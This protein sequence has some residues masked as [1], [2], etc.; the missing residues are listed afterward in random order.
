MK[1][2]DLLDRKA[3]FIPL[4]TADQSS[5]MHALAAG[6]E[7]AGAVTDRA[8][9]I[10]ALEKREQTGSTGIGFEVAIPHGKSAGVARPAIAFAKPSQPLDWQSLDGQPVR[11]VIMI[12]V[13]EGAG[14]EHLQILIAISRKLIDDQFRNALL[15]V[16]SAD[17]LIALLDSIS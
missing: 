7:A 4:E 11:A 6:L 2:T 12:A 16:E 5:C 9:Y 3:I 8:A 15:G 17:E 14:N 10:E 1:I 13:P